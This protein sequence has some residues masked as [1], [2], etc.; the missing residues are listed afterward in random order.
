MSERSLPRSEATSLAATFAAYPR[1]TR[2]HAYACPSWGLRPTEATRR[3]CSAMTRAGRPCMRR[4]LPNAAERR[5][6]VLACP[7]SVPFCNVLRR[8]LLVGL[9]P[10]VYRHR[11]QRGD[12]GVLRTRLKEPAAVCRRFGYRRL[13]LLLQREGLF[14]Q[15]AL[16]D[17]PGG[18][19]SWFAM[20]A[21]VF[22]LSNC[23]D[24]IGGLRL[25]PTL[26]V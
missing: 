20:N 22:N 14:V 3:P 9:A 5:R 11:S 6:V 8:M 13:H 1:V 12:D 15:E 24:P 4:A 19:S 2:P 26:G 16:S 23:H 17:L 18:E 10:K 21:S 7:P 25:G